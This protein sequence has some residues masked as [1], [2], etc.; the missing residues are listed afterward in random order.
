MLATWN[1]TD[2]PEPF[3][4]SKIRV[5][6]APG[7]VDPT[8]ILNV[9]DSMPLAMEIDFSQAI[10]IGKIIIRSNAAEAYPDAAPVGL[11]PNG[12][13]GYNLLSTEI[14]VQATMTS[15]HQNLLAAE[16]LVQI[17]NQIS[18]PFFGRVADGDFKVIAGASIVA[19]GGVQIITGGGVPQ[20]SISYQ[21]YGYGANGGDILIDGQITNASFVNLQVNSTNPHNILTGASGLI[22][23]SQ[24][25]TLNNAAADGGTIN[26]RTAGFA[27]HNIFAGTNVGPAADIAINVN[28]IQGDL[29]I[30]ALPASKATIS[31]TA[32]ESGRQVITNSNFDTIGGLS[33]AASTLNINRP[34]STEKGD[35]TLTGNAVTIGSNVS[36]GTTGIGNLNVTATAG[37]IAV[38]SAAVVKA[39]GDSINLTASGNIA[40]Q[41]R[42]EAT[43]LKLAA[44]GSINTLTRT[45]TVTAT[46]GGSITLTDDDAITLTN[47]ATTGNGSITW[48][49]ASPAGGRME[50]IQ[51]VA[52]VAVH[53]ARAERCHPVGGE[54]IDPELRIRIG[55]SRPA[56]P[57]R[58]NRGAAAVKHRAAGILDPGQG[59]GRPV[60]DERGAGSGP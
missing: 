3:H 23:G 60:H 40:S 32:S 15:K 38:T 6:A 30:N 39:S 27:Q 49:P 55:P 25:I 37:D 4:L 17:E 36:A 2:Q 14:Y 35:L 46:S 50:R 34:I 51:L 43:N 41:A 52:A 1:N 13:G 5:T 58:E 45:D 7:T 53:R 22:S 33:L 59:L 8:F 56:R 42:L 10:G 54:A 44:G 12:G 57:R 18:G 9:G 26:V 19:N 21:T 29:T 16:H 24:S 48:Q 28:Q 31:L 11:L 20:N 47:L